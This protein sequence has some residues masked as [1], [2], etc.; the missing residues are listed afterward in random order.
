MGDLEHWK[1]TTRNHISHKEVKDLIDSRTKP[2]KCLY[3]KAMLLVFGASIIL[4]IFAWNIPRLM[5]HAAH[6]E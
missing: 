1:D 6:T 5:N 2:Y 4:S 3:R